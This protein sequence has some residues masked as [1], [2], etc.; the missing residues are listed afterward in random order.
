MYTIKFMQFTIILTLIFSNTLMGQGSILSN[1]E[2][3]NLVFKVVEEMPRFPGCEDL[4]TQAEKKK[5]AD[6]KMLEYIYSNLVYPSEAIEKNVV[7]QVVLQFMIEIDGSISEIK[8]GREIGYGCGQAAVDVIESMT[9]MGKV[10]RPGH[11]RGK[12]VR[13]LYTL[14]IKFDTQKK[15]KQKKNKIYP[16]LKN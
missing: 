10:W 2:Q 11:Q 3:E 8:I 5:C 12:P 14:P 6:A 16:S 7:G 13:V 4:E 1:S 15:D 9:K